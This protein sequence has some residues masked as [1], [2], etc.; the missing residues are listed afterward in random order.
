MTWKGAFRRLYWKLLPPA[1][2]KTRENRPGKSGKHRISRYPPIRCALVA[3]VI[4]ACDDANREPPVGGER[5]STLA[6]AGRW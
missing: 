5:H 4:V 3:V 2:A 1:V 6:V